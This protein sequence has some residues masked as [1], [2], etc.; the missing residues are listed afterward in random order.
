MTKIKNPR[1]KKAIS[2]KKDTHQRPW[3]AS[4]GDRRQRPLAKALE[5]RDERRRVAE[6]LRNGTT[7]KG[8]QE[9]PEQAELNARTLKTHHYRYQSTAYPLRESLEM[10]ERKRLDRFGRKEKHLS[11]RK[12]W[13]EPDI[14]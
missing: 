12:G 11:E 7:I 3:T 8:S 5:L 2:Y 1:Q 9:E 6:A 10:K 14:R 13:G 4:K